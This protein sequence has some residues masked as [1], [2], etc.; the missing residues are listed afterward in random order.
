MR[1]NEEAK[2]LLNVVD[3]DVVNVERMMEFANHI[4]LNP[5][6]KFLARFQRIFP[7]MIDF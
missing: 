3:W 4:F 5:V 6:V 7:Q 2:Y 1:M